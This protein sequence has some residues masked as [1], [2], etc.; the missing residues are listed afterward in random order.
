K[1]VLPPLE[2]HKKTGIVFRF[3]HAG[4]RLLST[5][6]SGIWRLWDTRTG[7]ELLTL[8]AGG[9]CLRFSADD[10][11]VAANWSPTSV[12]LYRFQGGREFRTVVHH[13]AI[14]TNDWM[15]GPAILDAE[16]RLLAYAAGD[17]IVLVDVPR[18]Q[19]AALL[20]LPNNV[21]LQ[22]EPR[23][24]A[25]WTYGRAGL[26]RWPLH[27]NSADKERRVGPPQALDSPSTIG[28]VWGGNP[29]V[30]L[31]AIPN[32]DQGALLWQRAANRTLTMTP[33]VGVRFCAVSPDGRWVATGSH[34]TPRD[35]VGV[36]VW[37][38][39]SGHHVMNL[40]LS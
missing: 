40:A 38:A 26:L 13:S 5:D 36:K 29:E 4:D 9:Y 10:R 30:N 24:E 23:G 39:Q 11:F 17:G 32:L 8:P 25:L 34:G 18:S 15:R 27:T 19:E 21:P 12:R 20:P 35:G 14:S 28:R 6:W 3:N 7:Q 1:L 31:V 33:Q 37:D 2:G 22:F 16:S